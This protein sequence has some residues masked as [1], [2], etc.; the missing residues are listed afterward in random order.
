MSLAG[1]STRI[2]EMGDSDERMLA[3]G[4]LYAPTIRHHNGITY[5]I[6]TNVIHEG[7]S[8]TGR[9]ENFILTTRDIWSNEWS[10]PIYFDFNGIDPSIF[11]DDDGRAYIQGSAAPGPMTKINLFEIDLQTGKKLSEEKK[12]WDGTGGIYPEGPHI[13]KKDG[14]YYLLISEGGTFSGHMITVARSKGIWGPYESFEGNPILTAK[15][16]D[17]YVQYTGHCDVFQ[18]KQGG[19]WGVCLAVRKRD[20]RYVMGRETFL[21]PGVWAAGDWPRLCRVKVHPQLPDGRIIVRTDEKT[22][23]TNPV[24]DLVYIRD[25]RLDD[26]QLT[27]DA[28]TIVLTPSQ[29]GLSSW[30]GPVTFVGKRQRQL[31]GTSSVTMHMATAA[32]TAGLKAGLAYY[33]DEHRYARVYYDHAISEMVFE[34]VNKARSISRMSRHT[35]DMQDTFSLRIEHTEMSCSFFFSQ[36]KAIDGWISAGKLDTIEMTGPDF[37]GPVVGVFATAENQDV[38]VR[39]DDLVVA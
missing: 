2:D 17:E 29:A 33:K 16:T 14:F 12:I 36:D 9:T 11:F 13:Y 35:C 38:R 21:T 23:M 10:D 32:D 30:R 18:D 39:F 20:G 37:V 31:E 26:H 1:S 15:G 24:V 28:K 25:A 7:E 8:H 4:G 6:C 27:K 34:V 5:I 3:T 22:I 19:W